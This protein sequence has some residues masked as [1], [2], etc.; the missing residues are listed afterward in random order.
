MK[1]IIFLIVV[2]FISFNTSTFAQTEKIEEG[3]KRVYCELVGTANFT[4]TKVKV[5]V[6]FGQK[7][8]WRSDQQLVGTDGKK[9][10]F[11]SMVDAMNYMG[12]FN[13]KFIQAY[14]ITHG[15]SN[16]YHFLLY[17]DIIH[18]SEITEGFQTKAQYKEEN[19]QDED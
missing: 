12:R 16:V 11:N 18:E 14:A 19:E 10:K 1:K 3:K 5:A 17:K 6:D 8:T 9:L 13:W 15:N 2:L 7:V 4:G